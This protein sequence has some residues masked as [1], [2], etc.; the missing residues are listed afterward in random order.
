MPNTKRRGSDYYA[1]T[2][3]QQILPGGGGE[4]GYTMG[5]QYPV[6]MVRRSKAHDLVCEQRERRRRRRTLSNGNAQQIYIVVLRVSYFPSAVGGTH[7]A[8]IRPMM[9]PNYLLLLKG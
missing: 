1:S 4:G 2:V 8:V 6:R 9:H 3:F 7:T 5:K